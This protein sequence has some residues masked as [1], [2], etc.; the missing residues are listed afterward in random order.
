MKYFDEIPI[1]RSI[2]TLLVVCVHVSVAYLNSDNYNLSIFSGYLNQISRLG[3]PIFAV[4]SAFLL[5]SSSLKRNFDLNYFIHSRF[6]KIF[7]PY[8]IWTTVYLFYIGVI[9]VNLESGKNFIEYYIY[10][11]AGY[12]LYFILTVI[13]FYFLFPI[14][15]KIKKGNLLLFFYIASILLNLIWLVYKPHL[16]LDIPI[17]KNIIFSRSFILNWISYF[18]LGIVFAKYYI[19]LNEII[20]K[21]KIFFISI[22]LI[23]FITFLLYIDINK[24]I[25]SSHPI[26][27]LYVPF[28]LVFLN[29]FYLFI[30][31]NK[32]LTNILTQIGNYSMG[33]YLVHPM[34]K[35]TVFKLPFFDNRNSFLLF[36][37]S[38][39]IIILAS[40]IVVGL[41]VKIPNG[42]YI[43]PVPKKSKILRNKK[44]IL[45]EE[46]TVN[47]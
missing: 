31:N 40:V 9:D 28:F 36:I 30:K 18:M 45:N 47:S 14:L 7:I 23:L 35:W 17:L 12:H 15:Y 6:T 46:S 26:F 19:E 27:L 34:I 41:I 20:R 22:I 2:A 3:T 32:S 16:N 21:Y 39:T 10:G 1:I 44:E 13:E 33:I 24:L 37:L 43:V 5:T 4:I 38:F 29:Y 11:T 8:L 25:T 42:N